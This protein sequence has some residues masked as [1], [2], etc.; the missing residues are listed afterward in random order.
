MV[1]LWLGRR[2]CDQQVGSSTPGLALPGKY[3][4]W[5]G[6]RLWTGKPSRYVT[7]H[8]GQLSLP[9]LDGVGKSS[10]D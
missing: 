9:S 5:M 2:T 4:D 8:I 1:V 6:D 10:T 3:L 7:S